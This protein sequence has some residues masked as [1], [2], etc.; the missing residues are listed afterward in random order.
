MAATAKSYKQKTIKPYC[1]ESRYVNFKDGVG[2]EHFANIC[3]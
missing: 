1:V 2:L 3:V